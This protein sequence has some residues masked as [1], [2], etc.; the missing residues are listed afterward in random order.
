MGGN[1]LEL[2]HALDSFSGEGS[3]CNEG[4]LRPPARR[5]QPW[6]K[7]TKSSLWLKQIHHGWVTE[8]ECGRKPRG[9]S[10]LPS[11]Q[12][13]PLFLHS[14]QET[15]GMQQR[16]CFLIAAMLR[17]RIFVRRIQQ[18]CLL[19]LTLFHLA[20]LRWRDWVETIFLLIACQ[21]CT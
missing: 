6:L 14:T 9:C 3:A 1:R 15:L 10:V 7:V 13:L 19:S 8:T 2:G 11:V 20:R 4:H 18:R 5:P 12:L 17:W 16:T 21:S